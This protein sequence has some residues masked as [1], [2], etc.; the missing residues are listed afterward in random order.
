[1]SYPNYVDFRDRNSA[2]SDLVAY[3]LNTANL[4][5][6]PRDNV[7]AWGY[8][9]TG[10]YFGA[11]GVAPELGRFFGPAED[12]KPGA[13]SV[14]VL[15]HQ[16]WRN[17]LAADPKAIGRTVK[18][19]GYSFTVIGIAPH[20]FPG[21]EL[22]LTADYWV[23]MSMELQVEAGNDWI[24][25][26]ASQNIW[27]LGRLKP[28]VSAA[29]AEANLDQIAVSLAQEHPNHVDPKAKFELSR[30]GLIGNYLRR[31]VARFGVVFVSV[32]G[33]GLLLACVNLAGMLLARAADRR[34][35][36]GIRL[37]LGA[38]RR[39]L[40]RQLMTE[41][42]LLG[43]SGG[44]LGF[45]IALVVCRLI[46]SWHPGFDLPINTTLHPNRAVL[47]FALAAAFCTTLLFGLAPAL[48][49]VRADLIPSLKNGQATGRLR[50]WGLRDILVS[51]Q[52][53]L[54]VMLV[55]CSV[56][57]VR[58][59]QHALS[60][61]LGFK[62]EG[63]VSVSFD[64][65]LRGYSEERIR[66]FDA[67]LLAKTSAIPGIGSAGIINNL[68]LRMGENNDTIS[69]ADQPIP[70]P[71]QRH[72]A[73]AYNISP[74]Y[75]RAAGT[76]LR[77]GRD[78]DGH[79]RP[80]SP[81]VVIVNEAC[82]HALFGR[83]DPLGKRIRLGENPSDE[84]VEVVGVV[85]D[86]KYE[87][88]GEAPHPAIFLPL[89]QV[90]TRFTTL[91]ARSSLPSQQMTELL[92]KAVLDLDPE[93]TL[94]NAGGLKDQLALPLFPVRIAAV[95]LSVFGVLAMVLAA[96]GLFALIAYAVSRR[97]REIGIRMAL[98][99]RRGQ[100]LSSVLARTLL[101]CSAGTLTGALVALG[102]GRVL[103]TV[104]Y[105]VSPRDPATY[106]VAILLMTGV[107]LLACWHPAMRAIRIDPA[108]TLR[109]E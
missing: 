102:A 66:A 72:A 22:I 25:S 86:G 32:A 2:F 85:E 40:V 92:R 68:P 12:D 76:T 9:A 16:F 61:N 99:A 1:M 64:L 67:E 29:Q 27:T 33:L 10:N 79:D 108:R 103:S 19:N 44:M 101:L 90:G 95:V 30:P 89:A 80:G 31:P 43:L 20:S 56:L 4:S 104:L 48:Q 6:Q 7:Y 63:A 24:H 14:I 37:A 35:E 11:L 57:V 60:L 42:L 69:R 13:N 3:R 36:V 50:G 84:G 49:T 81:R 78:I 107:A 88:L 15:S 109:E 45:A 17:R 100:V 73:I 46:S 39:Q 59:L 97:T 38:T 54:S 74:G 18:I 106:V 52:V 71:N 26:R 47:G 98:G 105:G 58:S 51:V 41:S 75:F 28:G 93:L 87:F 21:T 96:T 34:R 83:E 8:E 62:P 94:I 55:I 65:N 23:P 53:A 91:V 70:K 5:L 82:A 77:A